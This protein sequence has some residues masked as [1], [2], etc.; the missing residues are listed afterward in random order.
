VRKDAPNVNMHVFV[1]K[2]DTM[3]DH[4]YRL[5]AFR[6]VQSQIKLELEDAEADAAHASGA[7]VTTASGTGTGAGTGIDGIIWALTSVF[8]TT[9]HEAFSRTIH[10]LLPSLPFFEDLLN[11][12]CTNSHALKAFLFD[13]HTRL[14][15]ATD[16]TPVDADTLAWAIDYLKLL[17]SFGRLY[18][19]VS[20]L[21]IL[22]HG[23]IG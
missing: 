17:S 3:S 13:V 7:I 9:I 8:D 16:S 19:Y 2:A 14:Y 1:H 11:L 10:K 4:H 23:T 6:T 18:T 12:F 20:L 22:P 15:V 21:P 5:D